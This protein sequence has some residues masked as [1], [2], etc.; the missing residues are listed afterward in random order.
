M[1]VVLNSSFMSQKPGEFLQTNNVQGFT[2]K[3]YDL[4]DLQWV[5]SS[6]FFF[7]FKLAVSS[8][9]EARACHYLLSV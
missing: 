7:F 6:F 9:L 4:I 5:P 2:L 1:P 8:P 3:D